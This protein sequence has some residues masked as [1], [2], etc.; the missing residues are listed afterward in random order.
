MTADQQGFPQLNAPIAD[1]AT[2]RIT[3]PWYQLV[4]TLWNRTGGGQSTIGQG[5][6]SGDMRAFAGPLANIPPGWLPCDGRALSRKSFA[7]LFKA[8][9]VAWGEGDGTNTFNLPNAQNVVLL[10]AS[11]A[12][13]LGSTGGQSQVT[14]NTGNLPAHNHTINDLGHTHAFT[15]SP[16]THAITDPGHT[17]T[18]GTPNGTADV[19]SGTA[20]TSAVAGITGTSTAGI[21]VNNTTAGGTNAS[22]TTGVT[23]NNTGSGTP[24][25]I[26]QPYAATNFIIKT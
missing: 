21:T 14:L 12:F 2:G 18:D 23:T 13:P 15:G 7:N 22:A 24:V 10:G 3:Q 16:H 4:I 25:S 20:K 19:A 11:A 6:F 17:H 8:I 1:P 5:V 26:L 9:G